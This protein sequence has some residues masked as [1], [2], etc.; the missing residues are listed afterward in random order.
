MMVVRAEQGMNGMRSEVR[1]RSRRDSRMRVATMAGT[2]QPNP[3]MN[4]DDRFA[5]EA[6]PVHES[7]EE[8]AGP[9]QVAEVLQEGHQE[10]E[11]KEIRQDDG[12][13]PADALEEPV[14]EMEERDRPRGARPDAGLERGNGLRSSVSS[15]PA[16]LEDDEEEGQE[17]GGQDDIAEDGMHE[18]VVDPL[19]PGRCACRARTRLRLLEELQGQVVALGGDDFIGR[20]ARARTS[21][22]G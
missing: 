2:L 5:V 19:V 6:D 16:D 17:D 12:H 13:S 8:E 22:S 15:G 4:G 9:G 21:M 10:Q 1:T 3:R 11:R 18:D 14:G 20:G 7:V